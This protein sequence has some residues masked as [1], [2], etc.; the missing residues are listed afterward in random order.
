MVWGNEFIKR[1]NDTRIHV[2]VCDH[3]PSQENMFSESARMICEK[4]SC[5]GNQT[6]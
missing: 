6:C 4:Y 5:H 1:H 3:V 2:F